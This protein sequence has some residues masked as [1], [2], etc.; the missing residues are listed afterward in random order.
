[1]TER[2]VFEM[3]HWRARDLG[4][5]QDVTIGELL[6][7]AADLAPS[8]VALVEG[9]ADVSERR[10]W[11]YA[12]LLEEAVG[13]G[14]ALLGRFTPGERVAVWSNNIPEWILLQLGTALAGITLVP[15]DPALRARELRYV[16]DHSG[17]VGVF[18]K[19]EY[20]SNAMAASLEEVRPG[21]PK[22]REVVYFEDWP[23]FT[24]SRSVRGEL[25][26]VSA[27]SAA[28]ILYTSGTT[29][30]PKGVVLTHRGLVNNARLGVGRLP[31]RQ[32]DAFVNSMPLFHTVGSGVVTL[33]LIAALATH[34]LMPFFEPGLQ[35]RLLEEERSVVVGGVPTMLLALLEHERFPATDTSTL[36]FAL[37]GGAMVP[38]EL[39]RRVER[40]AGVPLAIVYGQ[41]EASPT[42]TMV[43]PFKDS[44]DERTQTVGRPLPATDLRIVDPLDRTTLLPVGTVGEIC[45]R[46]YHLMAGYLD[47]PEQTAE[48][49]DADGW[50]HTGD[51]GRMDAR[52]CLSIEGRLKEM[53][54][55]GGEN[56]FPS[57]IENVLLAHPDVHNVAV[58]GVPD[59]HWGEQ[60][61]AFVILVDGHRFDE[62]E[63]TRY[64]QE[65]LARH[66]VPR[67]WRAVEEFP[68]TGSG[69]IRKTVLRESVDSM[70]TAKA[71]A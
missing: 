62:D 8:G 29:G 45:T 46:G 27:D 20:R 51:L 48:A 37:S 23:A 71:E 53:I 14:R 57:E 55:R 60:V 49:I 68:K 67:I 70:S 33:G 12:Q 58:V 66:K 43:D 5:V 18:L 6:G 31:L 21:L 11:T 4:T 13:V 1:M 40:E 16:L 42:I 2:A 38:S 9:V 50:L 64:C 22:L 56:V 10:R 65:R 69:K 30:V 54:I 44:A 28:Q 63:L 47:A 24:A 32:G 39:A 36:R 35:L 19:S 41:T 7:K 52:G 34:V 59:Q 61:A 25:P 3:S 17:A 15:V 26:D